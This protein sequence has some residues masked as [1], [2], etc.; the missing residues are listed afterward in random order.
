MLSKKIFSFI[1]LFIFLFSFL[2]S[3]QACGAVVTWQPNNETDIAGYC[4]YWNYTHDWL[5]EDIENRD[6]AIYV[7]KDELNGSCY[8]V[9]FE[10]DDDSHDAIFVTVTA[11]DYSGNESDFQDG[12]YC[13]FGNVVGNYTSGTPYTEAVVDRAD[14]NEFT[15]YYR[16]TVVHPYWSCDARDFDDLITP[17]SSPQICDFDKDG[18]I[19]YQDK[20]YLSRRMGKTAY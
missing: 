13:L 3:G 15:R 5:L 10:A 1:V 12:V 14:L 18:T 7:D 6:Y 8:G 9:C 2:L 11:I 19:S 20:T 4:V 16:K 17:L